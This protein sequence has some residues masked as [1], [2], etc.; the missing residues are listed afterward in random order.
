[1]RSDSC[2]VLATSVDRLWQYL[3]ISA[4]F[5][6]SFSNSCFLIDAN[7]AES[8]MFEVL[9]ARGLARVAPE[10]PLP[11]SWRTRSRGR[12]TRTSPTR[13][14]CRRSSAIG[15]QSGIYDR[16]WVSHACFGTLGRAR[17]RLYQRRFLLPS[18]VVI[19]TYLLAFCH[20]LY[21]QA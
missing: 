5:L 12:T 16:G 14:R 19:S 4:S 2:R 7:Y 15:T 3:Q 8:L 17:S 18:T 21:L 9:G 10:G 20:F 13:W 11:R 6:V 1:M